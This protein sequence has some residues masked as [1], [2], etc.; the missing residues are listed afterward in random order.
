MLRGTEPFKKFNLLKP[1]NLPGV[2]R[3]KRNSNPMKKTKN[4]I[5]WQLFAA[6]LV[7]LALSSGCASP[8]ER[9]ARQVDTVTNYAEDTLDTDTATNT[10]SMSGS[11]GTGTDTTDTKLQQATRQQGNH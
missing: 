1:K 2:K 7:G 3:Y 8:E 5:P 4:Y 9:G 6:A 11:N 10:G